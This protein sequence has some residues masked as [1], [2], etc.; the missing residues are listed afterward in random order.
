VN[1]QEDY[2]EIL[3]VAKSA[4]Q[5]EIKKAY[6]KVGNSSRPEPNRL[7]LALKY[8]PDT[9][10]GNKQAEEKLAQ[11]NNAYSVR[12]IDWSTRQ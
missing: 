5:D 10:Q 4:S 11:I 7:Q 1:K 3:G 9:N 2:Y 6:Y 12:I 8:H